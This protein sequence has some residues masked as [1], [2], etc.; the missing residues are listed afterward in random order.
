MVRS[1]D[2]CLGPAA[3]ADHSDCGGR[4]EAVDEVVRVV[5]K[6][7][8]GDLLERNRAFYALL[9]NGVPVSYRAGG[10]AQTRQAMLVDFENPQANGFI[11][12]NQLEI[13]GTRGKRIPDVILFVNGLPLVVLELKH[14]LSEKADLQAAFNQLQT[15]KAE[16]GDLFVFNQLLLVSD[17]VNARIGSL[18]ADWQRFMPWRVV[19]ETANSARVPFAD[20]LAGVVEGLLRPETLLDYVR[21]FVLFECDARGQI[22]K[23]CAAYHQFYG[24]NAAVAATLAASG[25][26]GDG[27]I[28]VMWHTQGSGKSI[29]MLFYAGKLLAQRAL[30]NPTLV[31][32]TDRSDLD[33][34]LFQTFSA[35]Q[36]LLKQEP[37]QADSRE[38]L[39]QALAERAAGGVFFTT[40][41]KFAPREDEERFPALSTRRNIIVIS[42]EAHRS[43]YGFALK[44]GSGGQRRAGYARHLRGAL[45]NASFIGFTGTPLSLDD[46]DTQEVFGRYVSVYDLQDAVN[47][48]A[49]VPIVYEARQIRLNV[50]AARLHELF[51]DLDGDADEASAKLRLRE[52]ILGA[53]AIP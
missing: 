6:S 40:M 17:G 16:I 51:E 12:V 10:E 52:H 41:Q 32:V 44:V 20:E 37:V 11:A 25:E 3:A 53:D 39:R 5:T 42:D 26:G 9:R 33:G 1:F 34:Q 21:F 28:G 22:V 13:R 19:D 45:P 38:A 30:Q 18:S 43:Q 46:K 8:I 23:K 24:V 2:S 27:R 7:E 50:D 36:E 15:Y 35:G 47:D 49:T 31:V 29:S 48:G 14:P 4:P